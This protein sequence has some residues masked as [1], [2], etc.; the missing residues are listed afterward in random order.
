MRKIL[1]R[2]LKELT[3]TPMRSIIGVGEEVFEVVPVAERNGV[4]IDFT[5]ENGKVCRLYVKAFGK[6]PSMRRL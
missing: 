4:F 2:S 6:L 5:D 1:V 3:N